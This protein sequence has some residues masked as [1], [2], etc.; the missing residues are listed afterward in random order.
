MEDFN[1]PIK[2]YIIFSTVPLNLT[3]PSTPSGTLESPGK[4]IRHKGKLYK[5]K[6]NLLKLLK[7]DFM[8]VWFIML[9]T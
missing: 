2:L 3:K 5:K 7:P 4:I 1:P 6:V 8:R 9:I